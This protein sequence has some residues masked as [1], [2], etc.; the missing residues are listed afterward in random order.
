MG[1]KESR[2]S[3][4]NE[5]VRHILE[6]KTKMRYLSNLREAFS[7]VDKTWDTADEEGVEI[8]ITDE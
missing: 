7:Q 5:I 6:E 3:V 1:A 4:L 8:K 2:G